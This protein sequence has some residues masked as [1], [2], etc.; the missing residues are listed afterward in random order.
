[1][2]KFLNYTKCILVLLI[3]SIV[4]SCGNSSKNSAVTHIPVQLKIDGN[5]SLLDIETGAILFEGEFK[6]TPSVVTEGVFTTRNDKDEIFYNKIED[7]KVFKQIA[8]PFKSASL[9]NQGLAIVCKSESHLSAIND[10]GEDVFTLDPQ[11]GIVIKQAGQCIDGLIKFEDENHLWGFLDKNGKIAIKPQ[12]DYVDDFHNG[13]ARATMHPGKKDKFVIINKSGE[14]ESEI[15]KGFVGHLGNGIVAYSDNKKEFGVLKLGKVLEKKISASSKFEIISVQND[16]I[17]YAFEKSWGLL[18]E[19]GE[20]TIRAKY[21]F[22]TR[23]DGETFLGIKKDGDDVEY[24]I[25]NT[26]GEVVKKDEVDNTNYGAFNLHSN[27]RVMLKDGKE[28]QLINAK[29]ENV[30]SNPVKEWNGGND[31]IRTESNISDLVESDYFDW[32]KIDEMIESIKSGSLSGFTVGMNCVKSN[33]LLIKFASSNSSATSTKNHDQGRGLVFSYKDFDWVNLNGTYG[34]HIGVG[35][36]EKNDETPE[37]ESES[38]VQDPTVDTNPEVL[39]NTATGTAPAE[40]PIKDNSPE[41]NTYQTTLSESKNL[42]H[43]NSIG[44]VLSFD[45][46]IKKAV[47]KPTVVDYGYTTMVEEKVIGYERN[48]EAKLTMVQMEFNVQTDKIKKLKTKLEE[49][50]S[51]GF[52]LVSTSYDSKYYVDAKGTK[53][54]LNGLKIR[55]IQ[56]YSEYSEAASAVQP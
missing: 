26:K 45:D 9:M 16:D 12:F 1:M 14:V 31:I 51:K 22:L 13:L 4:T 44:L 24:E 23:L 15:D 21:E 50:F 53:W 11:D 35:Y 41:W 3:T 33:D 39:D 18:N 38:V 40:V 29:G 55:L 6:K 47:T 19:D 56:P 5:W 52:Q 32:A 49:K 28:Y 10:K 42:G 27:G 30:G 54:E 43:D 25:L 20:I 8:G 48:S 2:K 34:I 7:E 37:E 17:F 46:Y 36:D